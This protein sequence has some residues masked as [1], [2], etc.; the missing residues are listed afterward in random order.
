M[1]YLDFRTKCWDGI[2]I[3]LLSRFANKT[4]KIFNDVG[5]HK[6]LP[7][8]IP[9]PMTLNLNRKIMKSVLSSN[10]FS[11]SILARK[12]KLKLEN[13]FYWPALNRALHILIN[14][15]CMDLYPTLLI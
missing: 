6:V 5:V 12:G 9:L 2:E 7:P 15:E 4:A 13:Y 14:I 3:E 10:K 8:W 1:T 11:R